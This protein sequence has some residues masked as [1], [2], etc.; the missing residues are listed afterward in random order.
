MLEPLLAEHRGRLVKLMGDG[1][2]REFGSVVDAV[3][4]AAAIQRGWPKR[5]DAGPARGRIVLRIGVN[6]G[7]V[8]V[9]G[10]D[11]YGDGVNVAARLEQACPPGGIAGLR[12]RLRPAPG[13]ARLR[14][15]PA[16]RTAAQEHRAAGAGLPGRA[17]RDR[18]S[19]GGAPSPSP[20]KPAVA[21]LP[22]DNLSGDPEQAYFSDGITEDVITE[23]SRFR[24]LLV[25][26][27]NSSFAFRGKAADVREIG[28]ALGAGYVVEGSVRRAGEPGADHRPADRR[29]H[30]ARTCGRSATTGRSRTC[31]RSRTRSRAAS[32]PPWPPACSRR[33]RPPPG[34]G[35]RGTCAPTTCSCRA[36]ACRTC[37]RPGRRSR[38]GT[39]FEQ[40]RE[41][42]PTFARA[43]TGLAF[44][45][46]IRASD[47]GIGV[48]R[49]GRPR[50]GRGA[51][52]GRAGAALDPNDPRVH[53]AL[54]SCA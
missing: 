4:C 34:A 52:P 31:S 46:Y 23:L 44:N 30:A 28:R 51:A 15:R 14:L 43:Y 38:P 48:P 40:A 17:R 7:D 45:H 9:E 1:A 24:E 26:A 18:R 29:R 13:Q 27:R 42:D 21:V 49:D 54:G 36:T 19:R 33:A 22:F 39:L 32:S 25:I 2:H 6:L 50:P 3:A 10:D 11:L 20:D 8:V 35:R 16:G 37:S 53:Y 41:L 47:V 5:Q 12:H